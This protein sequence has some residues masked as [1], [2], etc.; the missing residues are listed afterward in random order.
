MELSK[1]RVNAIPRKLAAR[2][3][4]LEEARAKLAEIEKKTYV[5]EARKKWALTMVGNRIKRIE[6]EIE[7]LNALLKEHS[8]QLKH[9][10]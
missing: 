6:K 5:T 10:E 2:K 7:W 8:D 3:K 9:E 4:R 1:A